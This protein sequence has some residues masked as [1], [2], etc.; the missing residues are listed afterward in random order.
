MFYLFNITRLE[1]DQHATLVTECHEQVEL[2]GIAIYGFVSIEW[3]VD[4]NSQF[5]K[6][7][8]T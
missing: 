8:I 6:S 4:G 7:V 3:N 5:K 2:E 1:K